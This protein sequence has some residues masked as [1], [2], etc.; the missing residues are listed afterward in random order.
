MKTFIYSQI[1]QFGTF[2]KKLDLTSLL[3]RNEWTVYTNQRKINEKFIFLGNNQLLISTNGTISYARWQYLSVNA[4]LI[5]E[6]PNNGFLMKI[7]ACDDNIIVLNIDGTQQY[8]FFINSS[9]SSCLQ[10]SYSDLQLYLFK[11]FKIDILTD[12]QRKE[13]IEL[14][15][16]KELKIKKDKKIHENETREFLKLISYT[17]G[18]FLIFLIGILSFHEYKDYQKR[19]PKLHTTNLNQRIAVDLGLSV[20]WASCNIGANKP[21]EFGNYYGWGDPTG[22]DVFGYDSERLIDV[23]KRFPN[24]QSDLPPSSII[25]S[26]KDIAKANWGSDWRMPSKAEMQELISNCTIEYVVI[27]G[28]KAAKITGPSGKFILIPSAGFVR[29]TN[30]KSLS[31]NDSFSIYL[32]SGDLYFPPSATSFEN[33][34]AHLYLGDSWKNNGSEKYKNKTVSSIERY[35]MLPVRAVRDK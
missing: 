31:S 7:I 32:W 18:V 19:N 30:G 35:Y 13:L 3:M 24:R 27:N 6:H 33:S 17:V 20:N 25:G 23:K 22:K 10:F 21:E 12:E 9:N 28:T 11:K 16:T 4:S 2:D 15:Q 5:I 26:S 29:G 14:E 1:R 8:C 34:A